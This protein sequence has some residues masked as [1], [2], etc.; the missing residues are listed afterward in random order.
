MTPPPADRSSDE[1][2]DTRHHHAA[3]KPII[4]PMRWPFPLIWVV[5]I[6]ALVAAGFYLRDDLMERG[7]AIIIKL[8]DGSGL[9]P[10]QTPIY[11]LGVQVGTLTDLELTP[12]QRQV[13]A[14][15]SL[16]SANAAFAKQGALYWV[17]RPEI[18]ESSIT[19]LGA[20]VSGPYIEAMPGAG[21]PATQFDGLLRPPGDTEGLRIVLHSDRLEHLHTDSPVYFR[22]IQVG[23]VSDIEL[24]RDANHVDITVHIFKLYIPLVRSTSQFWSASGADVEGGVFSGVHLKLDSLRS[25]ISGGIEFATPDNTTGTAAA[26]GAE[27]NLHE[28]AKKEW[29]GWSP[30]I[31]IEPATKP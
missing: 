6:F 22:G 5:P 24:A 26:D 30:A 1:S 25:L 7:V 17:V 4:K 21:S 28:D 16:R 9:K 10:G 13:L 19:G 18:S 27:F 3:P 31:P 14:H 29:L 23:S 8:N 2:A 11:H 12:D 15:V 20:I